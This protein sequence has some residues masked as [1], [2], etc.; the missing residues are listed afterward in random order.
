VRK[1]KKTC[2][3]VNDQKSTSSRTSL[4]WQCAISLAC[5]L[6]GQGQAAHAEVRLPAIISNH[7]L[8]QADANPRIWGWAS[9]GEKIEVKYPGK[10][11]KT[12]ADANGEW[13]VF[14]GKIKA[15]TKFDLEITGTNSIS[16]KDVLAGEV[17]V[18]AGQS[19]MEFHLSKAKNGNSE[20]ES[21][22]WPQIRFFKVK[23]TPSVTPMNDVTGSWSVYSPQAAKDWSA[24]GYFFAKELTQQLERPIGMIESL[25][26]G[27][28]AQVW[29]SQTALSSEDM[30]RSVQSPA[31]AS[32]SPFDAQSALFNG[33]INGITPYTVRGITWYQGESNVRQPEL[34]K[35]LFPALIE[36]WRKHWEIPNLPFIFVQLPNF[37]EGNPSGTEWA[38]MREAQTQAVQL[39][40]TAMVVT[41]DV[42]ESQNKHPIDKQPVGHRLALNALDLVYHKKLP[43]TGPVLKSMKP[44]PGAIFCQF[45]NTDQGLRARNG[46][47]LSGFQVC[48]ADKRYVPAAGVIKGSTITLSS[49]EVAEPIA[50]RYAWANDPD[51]N[52][53]N[54]LGLPAAP[55]RTDYQPLNRSKN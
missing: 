10:S 24:V 39:K 41:I 20:L 43:C 31:T 44:L 22:I 27:T 55:F 38:E 49:P 48:G 15:G 53:E 37:A 54:G 9:P 6:S 4:L 16:V 46:A 45:Y 52:L 29:I 8:V 17:W 42:G 3:G 5:L 25:R 36:D 11:L 23:M 50:I 34:Y 30:V 32:T 47:A 18:C 7:M 33:M 12:V 26:G 21:H 19:N 51:A 1:M 13:H 35:K 2:N 14:L 40:N 28:A